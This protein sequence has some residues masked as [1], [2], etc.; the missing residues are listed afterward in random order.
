VTPAEGLILEDLSTTAGSFALGPVELEVAP[1]S[2]LVVLGPSG[3]GKTTLLD[4]IAGFR[5]TTTGRVQLAG[6]DLTRLAP[7]TRRIG[8]VFQH[9]A[10]FP[11]LS[12]RENVGFALRARGEKRHGH[13]KDLLTRFGLAAHAERRPRALSGGERQRV[14]LARALAAEP[15]LLLLDEPLSALDQPTREELRGLL[16]DLLLGLGIPAVHVTHDRDEALTLADHIAIIVNGRLRQIQPAHEITSRP[17][18]ADAAR[19][20][21]WTELGHGTAR[22]GKIT[23]GDLT[24]QAHDLPGPDSRPVTVFYRPET[25]LLGSSAPAHEPALR[26]TRTIQQVLPT[27]P[28]TRVRLSGDPPLSALVLPR[29][30]TRIN[31]QAGAQVEVQLPTDSLKTFIGTPTPAAGSASPVPSRNLTVAE[32]HG[33][34]TPP[35][36]LGHP[37]CAIGHQDDPRPGTGRERGSG[38]PP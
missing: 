4:V 16:Q 25:V 33:T 7:E 12:V 6:R 36:D 3:A 15:D 29:E 9:A 13:V 2:V 31:P 11:H 28:L 21:G 5:P 20:L 10:L 26:L 34:R 37:G 17:V 30:L 8:V 14:A 38:R 27:M 24:L 19:L 23:L 18:D 22:H 32:H 35:Q 1:G